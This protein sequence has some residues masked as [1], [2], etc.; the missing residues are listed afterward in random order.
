MPIRFNRTIRLGRGFNINL[1]RSGLSWSWGIPKTGV[2]YYQKA[3]SWAGAA[4]LVVILLLL[5][6]AANW[7]NW[8]AP[9]AKPGVEPANRSAP[10]ERVS[11]GSRSRSESQATTAT[12]TETSTS[13]PRSASKTSR[14]K[15]GKTN[16]EPE[17]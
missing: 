11:S 12:A 4:A 9:R 13:R 2:R 1:S 5:F 7:Q 17:S 6:V 10:A 8:L 15:S 14:K 3:T 16:S